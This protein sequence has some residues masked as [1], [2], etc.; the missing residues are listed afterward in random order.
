MNDTLIAQYVPKAQ[1]RYGMAGH[2]LSETL[3]ELKDR[4]LLKQ[5]P[6]ERRFRRG[7]YVQV[8]YPGN[9]STIEGLIT[10]VHRDF[11]MVTADRGTS[12]CS[13]AECLIKRVPFEVNE[14]ERPMETEA[15]ISDSEIYTALWP[16][17]HTLS[18]EL[19][20]GPAM[21]K[22]IRDLFSKCRHDG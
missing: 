6:P 18:D 2:M 14:F 16:T 8:S 22:R 3:Q 1:K 21:L 11:I 19:T 12:L 7:D 13:F 5:L 10:V 4:D 9:S 20:E 15:S 17:Y